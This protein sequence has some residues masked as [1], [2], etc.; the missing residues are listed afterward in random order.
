MFVSVNTNNQT[1]AV[2][3]RRGGNDGPTAMAQR[4]FILCILSV[5][6]KSD[7]SPACQC[8]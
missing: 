6:Q 1:A 8:I 3:R 7:N 2:D 5:R 4:L